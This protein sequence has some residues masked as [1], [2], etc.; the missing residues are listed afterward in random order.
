MLPRSHVNSAGL[1]EGSAGALA[2]LGRLVDSMR[3]RT[4]LLEAVIENFPG[5]IA[6]YDK[7]MQM[8]LC[9]QRLIEMLD[10]PAWLFAKGYP[11]MEELFR[12]NASR[13]EYGEG[14]ADEQVARRVALLHQRRA[15]VYE[16]TRPNGSIIEIRGVPLAAGG[17]VT[18]YFDVTDQRATQAL[19]AHM[20][21]H[22]GLTDLPNRS[23]FSER[24]QSAITLAQSDGLVAVHY[25]D[26]DGFKRVNDTLGHKAGD[27]LLRDVSARLR[28]SV[29]K[30]D[31]VARLGGDEFA[32]V[33]TEIRMPSDAGV[34]ADR[35]L[36]RVRMTVGLPTVAIPVGVSIGVAFAPIDGSTVDAVLVAA[37]A[38]LY[39]SKTAGR[40]RYTFFNSK[41]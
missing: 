1:S 30:H 10:Y 40:G 39:R 20:A 6:L 19:V 17:F 14:N 25:L 32:I 4:E 23:L 36:Q 2:D 26:L 29:R 35:V 15:H 11:S 38:A 34:L 33:Q 31:T 27:E 12:F 7:T 21:H 9:N 24:L 22:D 16:R 28:N 5:G 18:T 41:T 3:E 8:V 13:G 37:D